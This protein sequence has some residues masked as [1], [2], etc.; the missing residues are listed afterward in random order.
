MRQEAQQN[1][2]TH[3]SWQDRSDTMKGLTA[4]LKPATPWMLND[5]AFEDLNMLPTDQ[6]TVP[7]LLSAMRSK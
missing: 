7:S 6:F 4:K 3:I 5:E 2:A 1:G